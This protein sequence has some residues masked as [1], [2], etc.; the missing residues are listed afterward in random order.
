M[1]AVLYEVEEGEP[2]TKIPVR[3]YTGVLNNLLNENVTILLGKEAIRTADRKAYKYLMFMG[4]RLQNG[5]T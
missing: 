5:R 4:K 3:D 1:A 2:D